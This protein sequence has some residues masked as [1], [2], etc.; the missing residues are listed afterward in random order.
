MVCVMAVGVGTHDSIE[1]AVCG[2]SWST[3]SS[4]S[5]VQSPHAIAAIA[6]DDIWAVGYNFNKAAAVLHPEEIPM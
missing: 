3:V 2:P 1:A 5:Q 6:P 4:P